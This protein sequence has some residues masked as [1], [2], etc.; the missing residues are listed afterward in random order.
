MDRVRLWALLLL[1][2][3]AGCVSLASL[4]F[5]LSDWL[6]VA[7]AVPAGIGGALIGDRVGIW[8]QARGWGRS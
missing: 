5:E 3:L 1:T 4:V 8:L 2:A 7:A 6:T